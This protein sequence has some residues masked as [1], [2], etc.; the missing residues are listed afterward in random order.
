MLD[1]KLRMRFRAAFTLVELLVAITVT[2][3]L[4][5]AL[6]KTF[7][8]IGQSTKEGRAQVRLSAKMRGISFRLRNELRIRTIDADPPARSQDG[9]GYFMY[10]EGPLTEHTFGLFGAE[11][12]RTT[13]SGDVL[14]PDNA[15]YFD[16]TVRKGPTYRRLSRYG[17][18]DDYIAFTAEATGD[19]W[20][21]GKVPAYLVDDEAADP[22]EPRVIRSKFAEIIIW[23]S[24]RWQVNPATND[25]LLA[26]HPSAMPLYV[27]AN[28]DLAPDEIVLHQRI[29]LI[30]PDLNARRVVT[31]GNADLNF[32]TSVL[33]PWT[34]HSDPSRV[35]NALEGIYP[36]GLTNPS[37]TATP[38]PNPLYPSYAVPGSAGDNRLMFASNWLVGM[39]PLHQFYDLSLRRIV[40]PDTGEPTPYV[41]ANSLQ[42]LVQPHNRF[43]H[44]RYPGRYMGQGSFTPSDPSADNLTSMPLLALGW[45]DAILNWQGTDDPRGASATAPAWFPQSHPSPRTRNVTLANSSGL[46][47]GWLLPHFELGDPN[48]PG[49]SG[50]PHWERGYFHVNTTADPRWDRTGED[51]IATGILSFDV[52]G[53]DGS[54]P[55]FLTS[56]PDGAPG[57]LGVDDDASGTADESTVTTAPVQVS[58]ELGSIGTDD[59]VVDVNDLAL[60]NVIGSSVLDPTSFPADPPD[61]QSLGSRGSFADL[62]YPYL[63]GSALL[64]RTGQAQST[65]IPQNFSTPERPSGVTFN[66]QVRFNYD[67]F[68]QTDLSLYPIP[69]LT[70]NSLKRSGKLVHATGTGGIWLM[71]PAYDTWTDF[72]E[73]DNFDQSGSLVGS[74][75]AGAAQNGTV[76][77][78]NDVSGLTRVPRA[79]ASPSF[80]Q[81][82]TG[83]LI[84]DE[85]ETSAPFASRLPAISVTI[86]LGETE[87]DELLDFTIIE[88]LQ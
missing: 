5:A 54:A 62:A 58:S 60:F 35:P 32:E 75:A 7:A 26:P 53:F 66:T 6:A 51:I 22:M 64:T 55:V 52:K 59:V 85:P 87:S 56:G 19:E 16:P 40:H 14:T 13:D 43:A 67:A 9:Q 2:L 45:N 31:N 77:I 15:Q 84:A 44:V 80:L 28:N 86:R 49:T 78:L 1:S 10:Y 21:T 46:F 20:F 57:Q 61:F 81:I 72:Y 11:P 17:D 50:S 74:V 76:W 83:L 68:L 34:N 3:L 39:T 38:A 69:T 29:L 33:R 24:P 37:S 71:Q 73:S 82:D 41:A 18:S 4:M 79:P 47:N 70:L 8:I 42:D 12:F 63:A 48:Q 27:D 65:T 30:R 25:L 36:I 23:A 88:E